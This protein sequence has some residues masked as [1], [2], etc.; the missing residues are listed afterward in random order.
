VEY[1]EKEISS[2][3]ENPADLTYYDAGRGFE[4]AGDLSTANRCLYYI[5]AIQAFEK[6]TPY[7]RG[8]SYTAYGKTIP[9]GPVRAENEKALERVKSKYEKAW[10][11]AEL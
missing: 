10:C 9:L 8:E 3:Q 4:I 2:R 1:Y 6:E 7:I 11:K 5:K